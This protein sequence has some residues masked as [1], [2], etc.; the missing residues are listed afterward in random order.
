MDAA[1]KATLFHH[2]TVARPLSGAEAGRGSPKHW[3]KEFGVP[4]F[5]QSCM[6]LPSFGESDLLHPGFAFIADRD[7]F[8]YGPHIM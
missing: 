6:M 7:G 1:V 2:T 8:T 5:Q 3:S 4:C